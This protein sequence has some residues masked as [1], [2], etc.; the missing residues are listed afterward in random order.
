MSE[1]SNQNNQNNGV[2]GAGTLCEGPSPGRCSPVR[3]RGPGRHPTA[4]RTKWSK[5]VN[6]VVMECFFRSKPFDNNGKPIRGYRQQMIS[7]WRER[8]EFE[9]TEQR[10]CDQARAIRKNGWLSELELENI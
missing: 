10:L 2:N 3:Q 9:V 6:K 5:E 8:G 1:M 7:E 4:V